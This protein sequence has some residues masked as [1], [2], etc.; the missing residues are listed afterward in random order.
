VTAKPT[1]GLLGGRNSTREK[2]LWNSTNQQPNCHNEPRLIPLTQTQLEEIKISPR[3]ATDFFK[4][5][6]LNG[7]PRV[8]TPEPNKHFLA[9]N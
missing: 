3:H 9:E 7:W 1:T 5:H 6:N 4:K 2:P 8:I